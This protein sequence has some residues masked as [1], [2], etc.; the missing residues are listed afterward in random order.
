MTDINLLQKGDLKTSDFTNDNSN[1]KG[2]IG[3]RVSSDNGNLLQQRKT[4]LYYG[5]EAPPDTANLYVSSST[6]DDSNAGTRAAPLK[7]I[8]E[9][10]ER[11]SVGTVFTIHLFEDDTHPVHGS[12]GSISNGKAFNLYPYGPITDDARSRNPRSSALVWSSQ[13][14]RRPT[15]RFIYDG[16]LNVSNRRYARMNLLQTLSP[17]NATMRFYAVRFDMTAA[18]PL[19][20]HHV[21]YVTPFGWD[22]SGVSITF[23]GCDFI[24]KEGRALVSVGDS[25]SL[26][27]RGSVIDSS[28]G[29]GLITLAPLGNLNIV[30]DG[31][32]IAAGTPILT[33]PDGKEPL[34]YRATSP[35]TA[36]KGMIGA[37]SSAVKVSANTTTSANIKTSFDGFF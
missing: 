15:I 20:I 23:I 14:I 24:T 11:N 26:H 31:V 36:Y 18:E 34:T 7:T 19:P 29:G 28:N 13:E 5:I 35:D 2:G 21:Y 33:P 16:E 12:W 25:A 27:F 1:N 37:G 4:G 6:G 32:G 9:A 30:V 3:V 8:R 17:L 22:T 10:I